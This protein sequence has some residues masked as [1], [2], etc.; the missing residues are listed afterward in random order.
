MVDMTLISQNSML[1]P[2]FHRGL[3]QGQIRRFLV[4]PPNSSPGA[5]SW[6]ADAIAYGHPFTQIGIT[7]RSV[8]GIAYKT[9]ILNWHSETPVALLLPQAIRHR[10]GV[11]KPSFRTPKLRFWLT[12]SPF[13]KFFRNNVSLDHVNPRRGNHMQSGCHGDQKLCS[14]QRENSFPDFCV[15]AEIPPQSVCTSTPIVVAL[16]EDADICSCGDRNRPRVPNP[17][18]AL[19]PGQHKT[20]IRNQHSE[21]P[22]AP[23]CLSNVSLDHVNPGRGN[24]TESACHDDRK[25]CSTQ[26]EN[27]CPGRRYGSTNIADIVSESLMFT[28]FCLGSVDTR[29]GQVD[30]S[31]R[32][33]KTQLPDWDSRST[34]D[35]SR[36]TLVPD[37]RRA[38]SELQDGRQ[39]AGFGEF[40]VGAEIPPQSMCTS[41]L[42]VVPLG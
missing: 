27:S 24:H 41:T 21:M 13:P 20:T 23:Y 30:T 16:G 9:P 12:I 25:L 32:F 3:A 5:W 17:E 37:S 14:T 31:P 38:E 4:R 42:I 15:G 36:S 2:K 22:V 6:A 33:Q 40:C 28:H 26:C 29:S 11:E 8:I 10:F 39:D 34:L 7:F 18:S 1:G 19:R 35:Q